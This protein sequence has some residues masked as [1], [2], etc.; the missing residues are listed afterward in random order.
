MRRCPLLYSL[1]CLLLSCLRVLLIMIGLTYL[2]REC[3]WHYCG[4]M[5]IK[6]LLL[7][8]KEFN[9]PLCQRTLLT[10]LH[11]S[12]LFKRSFLNLISS[13]SLWA[14]FTILGERNQHLKRV[15]MKRLQTFAKPQNLSNDK[16]KKE[17]SDTGVPGR[18]PLSKGVA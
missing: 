6:G 8:F 16:C 18:E 14:G 15:N 1:S 9:F 11:V 12:F 2:V 4:N 5:N 17:L 7:F 10:E 3:E 13:T